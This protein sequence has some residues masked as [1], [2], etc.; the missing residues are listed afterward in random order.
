MISVVI[1]C[2]NSEEFIG[3]AIESVLNQTYQDFEVILVDNGSSDQTLNIL[4]SYRNKYPD[5]IQVLQEPR[6]GG[7]AARNKGLK[8]AKGEW[9]QFLDS[10][11]ELLPGK[12]DEQLKIARKNNADLVLSTFYKYYTSGGV[13]KVIIQ[14]LE[15]KNVWVGLIMSNLGRT[16]SNLWKRDKLLQVNGW[17]ESKTSSQEYNLL[18]S[19]LKL[20][21]KVSFCTIPLTN[22]Y[23]Q[24]NSIHK[25][26]NK[27]R[28]F[29]IA[30]NYINLRLEIK[31][32]LI[33]QNRFNEEF[34][35][36]VNISIYEH[37]QTYREIIPEFVT[38]TIDELKLN[39]PFSFYLKK[40]LR[41]TRNYI[42][43]Y[44]KILTGQIKGV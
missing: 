12:F 7:A 1:P 21:A 35:R 36:A 41:R 23:I 2:Y 5:F 31:K 13:Q 17:D 43:D 4:Y 29:E 44:A 38:I 3:R 34:N 22:I 42:N 11:D 30:N 16:S 8:E 18:F 26:A 25:S 33:S 27:K 9:I 28:S 6:K 32:Y 19:I 14:F 10:D 24:N 37:L 15:T 39:L 40:S 20:N